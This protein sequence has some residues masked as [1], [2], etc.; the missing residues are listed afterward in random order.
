MRDGQKAGNE[1]ITGGER[2][3]KQKKKMLNKRMKRKYCKESEADGG[4]NRS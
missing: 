2:Q 1:S 4:A 3:I